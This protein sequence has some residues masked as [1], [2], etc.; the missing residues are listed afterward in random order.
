MRHSRLTDDLQEQASLYAA[1][2]MPE[3]ERRDYARHLEEDQCA[4]CRAEVDEL[5]AAMGMLAFSVPPAAPSAT[6]RIRLMEQARNAIPAKPPQP[7]LRRY[8]LELITSA[9]A[10]ASLVAVLVTARANSELRQFANNLQDRVSELE[11]QV[12]QQRTYI[13]MVTAPETRVLRLAGQGGH[14]NASAKIIWETERSKWW[15]TARD[16]EPPPAGS[17]YQ[18]WFVPATGMPVSAGFLTPGG[19]G[20]AEIELD[21]RPDLTDLKVAAVTIEPAPGVPQPT[22][23]FALLSASE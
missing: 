16:L 4:V 19:D 18:L 5:Q 9:V 1:G 15:V 22:G 3:E 17:V 8:W 7:F 11:S 21:L 23:A 10:A 13:A 2:A 6:V 14:A 20:S 12:S